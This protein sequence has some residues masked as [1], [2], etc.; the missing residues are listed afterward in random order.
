MRALLILLTCNEKEFAALQL[1]QIV[2]VLADR[3]LYVGS[4]RRFYRVLRAHGQATT[5]AQTSSTPAG[6]RSESGVELGHHL[7]AHHR[8]WDLAVPLAGDRR[9]EPQG[10]GL[11]CRRA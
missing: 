10:G 5:G 7:L 4:E 3:G 1:G 8:A 2:P 9:L 11:G 6:C